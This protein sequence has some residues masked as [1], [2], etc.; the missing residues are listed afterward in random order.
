MKKQNKILLILISFFLICAC[1][2]I[3]EEDITNDIVQIISPIE[4]VV[5]EGNTVQFRWEALEGASDYKIQI[6]KSNQVYEVDSL[7]TTNTFTYTIDDGDYKWRVR[8]ENFA[9]QTPYNFPVNFTVEESEDLSNQTVALNTP[10][11]SFYTN[12]TNLTFTWSKINIADS[13]SFEL[14]KNL[15]GE[16]TVFQE[17]DITATSLN[18]DA[19]L[20]DE[21][22]EYIWKVKAINTASESSFAERSFFI[23][24]EN[25]S[26]PSL[27]LPADEEAVNPSL[28]TFNWTNGSDTGNIQS[29]ITNTLEISTGIDFNTILHSNKT[30]NNSAQYNFESANTYYWRVKAVDVASNESDYSVV[31]SI[32]VE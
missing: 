26:Q 8:G 19:S 29:V 11:T 21:D 10:S 22:S 6:I 14:V 27:S 9:Y 31:R 5:I 20:L 2:D 16:Q 30:E 4:G 1:D 24:T 18:I 7:V 28:I 23:D 25:P 13:Y 15:S 17:A 12:N 3:L 32:I